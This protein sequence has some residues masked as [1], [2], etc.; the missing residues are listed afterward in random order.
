MTK[1]TRD[2]QA[3][4]EELPVRLLLLLVGGVADLQAGRVV[5]ARRHPGHVDDGCNK[6]KIGE[7]T[8]CMYVCI[9]ATPQ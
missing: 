2:W 6:I 8:V 7:C 9:F 3:K 4:S 1:L 5:R